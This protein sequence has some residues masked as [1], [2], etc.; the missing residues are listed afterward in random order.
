MKELMENEAEERV[1]RQ[2]VPRTRFPLIMKREFDPRRMGTLEVDPAWWDHYLEDKRTLMMIH[3]DICMSQIPDHEYQK[4]FPAEPVL[5][6][7]E[8]LKYSTHMTLMQRHPIIGVLRDVGL[9]SRKWFF[10]QQYGGN[11]PSIFEKPTGDHKL[12]NSWS[13][14]LVMFEHK[15]GDD[16]V[17]VMENLPSYST[18]QFVRPREAHD[19]FRTGNKNRSLFQS[20]FRESQDI[21]SNIAEAIGDRRILMMHRARDNHVNYMQNLRYGPKFLAV[22]HLGA[23]IGAY[24]MGLDGTTKTYQLLR[25]KYFNIEGRWTKPEYEYLAREGEQGVDLTGMFP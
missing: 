20:K 14:G 5:P 18:E 16:P 23:V 13:Y 12:G 1:R 21:L 15:F 17:L 11:L 24:V 4:F 6:G 8:A 10:G 25:K 22:D 3:Q 19:A 7:G 9:V 2:G